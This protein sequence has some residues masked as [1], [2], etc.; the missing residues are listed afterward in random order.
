MKDDIELHV[1]T[2]KR[3]KRKIKIY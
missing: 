1:L 3:V 2:E